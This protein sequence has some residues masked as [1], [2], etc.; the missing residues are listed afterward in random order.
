LA[1]WPN[2]TG[3]PNIRQLATAEATKLR[4][5]IRWCRCSVLVTVR[6]RKAPAAFELAFRNMLRLPYAYAVDHG[7]GLPG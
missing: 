6:R 7:G 4:F 5:G 3:V 2:A 1:D